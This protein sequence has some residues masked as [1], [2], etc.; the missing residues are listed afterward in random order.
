MSVTARTRKILEEEVG[1]NAATDIIGNI[2]SAGSV[3][4][5]AHVAAMTV[6]A[7]AGSLPTANGSVTFATAT[8]IGGVAI[9]AT[10]G[11]L[12]AAA[13]TQVIDDADTPTVQELLALGVS[14]QAKVSSL[15]ALCASLLESVVELKKVDDNLIA[16]MI[17]A[18]SMAAS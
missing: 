10:T 12:P 7:S 3:G 16:A 4:A 14:L 18:G 8:A 9:T 2:V 1:I 6:T 5:A 17:A 15:S 13:G 11:S